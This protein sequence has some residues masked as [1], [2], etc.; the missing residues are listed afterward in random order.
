LARIRWTIPPSNIEIASCVCVCVLRN[1]WF[2]R[3]CK[4]WQEA[5]AAAA[6]AAAAASHQTR[7]FVQ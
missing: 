1:C 2:A 5:N 7:S 4:E 3:M 6:A